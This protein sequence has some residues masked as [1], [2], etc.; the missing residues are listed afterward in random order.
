[1][2]EN[3]RLLL[4]AALMFVVFLLWQNWL[5][6]QAMKH[7]PP[8]PP[9]VATAP[10]PANP[11][12]P[13]A[14]PGQDV[15]TVASVAHA[16]PGAQALGGGQR[17]RVI[18]DLFE[19]EIDTMG[20]DL[21]RVGLRTYPESVQQPDRPFLLLQDG[22]ADFFIAQSGL[23]ALNNG[24]APN[25]YAPRWSP[26]GPNTGWRMARTCWRYGSPGRTPP[27]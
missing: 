26:S 15:P 23:V 20:G 13:A 27:A 4:F 7:P 2:M 12:A 19:A 11:T 6:F 10:G 9:P 5:E 1:M 8:T 25:H 24:P 18:T 17:V 14:V 21:R 3:Q 22:G 16:A